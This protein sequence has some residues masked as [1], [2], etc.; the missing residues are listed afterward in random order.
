MIELNKTIGKAEFRELKYKVLP[1][2]RYQLLYRGVIFD[3][4][5]Y[6]PITDTHWLVKL[7]TVKP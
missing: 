3:G 7:V 4:R 6:D 2:G 1:D 5:R